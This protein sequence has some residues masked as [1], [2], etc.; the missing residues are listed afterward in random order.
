MY[1]TL[2]NEISARIIGYAVMK[3]YRFCAYGLYNHQ[4]ITFDGNTY[5]RLFNYVVEFLGKDFDKIFI[6]DSIDICVR[7]FIL[8]YVNANFPQ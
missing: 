6:D 7:S 3:K 5:K 1:T 8:S 4:D 2:N